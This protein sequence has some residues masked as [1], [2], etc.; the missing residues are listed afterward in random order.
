MYTD[1]PTLQGIEECKIHLRPQK[2]QACLAD[3]V[4]FPF[5]FIMEIVLRLP[6]WKLK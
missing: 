1:T 3:V 5:V 2:F 6:T 4:R